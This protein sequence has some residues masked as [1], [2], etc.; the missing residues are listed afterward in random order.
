MHLKFLT[1]GIHLTIRSNAE[2]WYQLTISSAVNCLEHSPYTMKMMIWASVKFHFK[3]LGNICECHGLLDMT[4]GRH[5]WCCKLKKRHCSV[6]LN[7][8][9]R[10]HQHMSAIW[11]CMRGFLM[12]IICWIA[13]TYLMS[14]VS[15]ARSY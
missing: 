11:S 13:S 14:S 10:C 9:F 5:I 3:S 7:V 12:Q 6:T 15:R 8:E 2:S 4:L 1:W